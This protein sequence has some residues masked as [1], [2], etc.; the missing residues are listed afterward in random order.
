MNEEEPFVNLFI[1]QRKPRRD[2][3]RRG[4]TGIASD[5]DFGVLDHL[6]VYS[7][8]VILRDLWRIRI[9]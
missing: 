5:L 4:R 6:G 3:V 7:P 1:K 8:H 9:H 2:E